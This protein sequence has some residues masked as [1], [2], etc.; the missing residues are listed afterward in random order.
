MGQGGPIYMH[1]SNSLSTNTSSY[2][3]DYIRRE[4]AQT[5][6]YILPS[7]DE[8]ALY[9]LPGDVVRAIEPNTEAHPVGILLQLL[10]MYGNIIGNV[11]HF[12]AEADIH[13]A[14]IFGVLVGRTG[15]GR[16]G[17][18]FGHVKRLF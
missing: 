16:K 3:S 13:P 4:V 2:I 8:A 15:K 9:G 12:R 5:S 11:P 6:P 1:F 10:T 18:A 7:L 14:K 17:V